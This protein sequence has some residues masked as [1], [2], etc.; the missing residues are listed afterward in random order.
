M[1]KGK[2]KQKQKQTL[3]KTKET[4]QDNDRLLTLQKNVKHGQEQY[5]TDFSPKVDLRSLDHFLNNSF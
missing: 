1:G 3:K 5:K 4:K 2:K